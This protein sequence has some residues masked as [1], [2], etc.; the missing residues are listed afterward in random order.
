VAIS[1]LQS[2]YIYN[3]GDTNPVDTIYQTNMGEDPSVSTNGNTIVLV[4]SDQKINVYNR[5]G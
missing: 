3:Y 2:I 4:S 5:V 1:K